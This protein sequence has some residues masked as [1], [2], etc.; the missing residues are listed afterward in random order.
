MSVSQKFQERLSK[1]IGDD[2]TFNDCIIMQLL[3]MKTS[4]DKE[5]AEIN[6]KLD[7]IFAYMD[8][9][10]TGKPKKIKSGTNVKEYF[11]ESYSENPEQYYEKISKSE[12]D[13]LIYEQDEKYNPDETSPA[14]HKMYAELIWEHL[15]LQNDELIEELTSLAKD[16]DA[17]TKDKR[18]A[19][20]KSKKSSAAKK[21][22]NTSTENDNIGDDLESVNDDGDIKSNADKPDKP[23]RSTKK[24]IVDDDGE[25]NEADKPAKPKRSTKKKIV[26]DDGEATEADKPAKPKRS[27]KKKIVD[28]D[29]EATEADKPA[30]PKRSTKTKP[31]NIEAPTSD[32]ENIE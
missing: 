14:I 32:T 8:K 26:D 18:T 25:A 24:K 16:A 11:I 7:H 23:K 6:R 29:G 28:N 30:K 2:A 17:A 19:T 4:M 15:V 3:D 9:P 10:I 1:L 5:L 22:V 31:I 13:K 21:K 12:I 27:T 20:T